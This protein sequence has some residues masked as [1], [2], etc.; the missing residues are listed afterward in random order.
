MIPPVRIGVLFALACFL[1]SG[2]QAA[3]A[4]NINTAN[5]ALLETLPGVGPV[6]A[7]R[8]IDYRTANGPFVEIE[9]IQNVKGIG[10]GS[11]YGKIASLITVGQ[12]SPDTT[13]YERVQEVEPPAVSKVEP[14]AVSKVEPIISTAQNIQAY[15]N[16]VR[17]PA[18]TTE[19]AAAGAAL[20]TVS[21]SEP[22]SIF[23]SPWFL[24]FLGVMALAGSALMFL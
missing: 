7:G 6:I 1:P 17:A 21:T 8:I 12:P 23:H 15:E 5:A 11:T 3:E 20:P 2:A 16:A 13:S 22:R 24:S 18:T 4:V 9:D 14:S 19:L 10:S